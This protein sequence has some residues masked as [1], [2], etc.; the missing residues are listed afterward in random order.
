M[1]QKKY[2]DAAASFM[3]VYCTFDFPELTAASLTE[4]ARALTEDKKAEQAERL[5]QRVIKDHPQS[6]WA[7]VAQKR[8]EDLKK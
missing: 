4:A 3:T 2:S 6:E 8:L 1:E 7:K 5:L